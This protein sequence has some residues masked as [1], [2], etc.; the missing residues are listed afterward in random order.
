MSSGLG[1]LGAQI[2]QL[3]GTVYAAAPA[4]ERSRILEQLIKPLG[5]LSAV[6]VAGGI[7]AQ[8]RLGNSHWPALQMAPD[9]ARRIKVGDVVMLAEHVQQVSLQALNGLGQVL[10]TSP[11]LMGS[12]ATA[13]LLAALA[14]WTQNR[15]RDEDE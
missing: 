15:T 6:T 13:M 10:T 9:Q 5:A 7:F 2:P 4:S 14:M 3:V 8:F 1:G 11:V 12:T